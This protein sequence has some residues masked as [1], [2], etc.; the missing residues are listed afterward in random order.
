MNAP[1]QASLPYLTLSD[2]RTARESRWL[3][4]ARTISTWPMP[5][6]VGLLLGMVFAIGWV[7]GATIYLAK[8]ADTKELSRCI[9][10]TLILTSKPQPHS[11]TRYP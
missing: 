3:G 11:F 2:D 4:L 9:E 5:V 10:Q 8:P 1:A 6:I 7:A